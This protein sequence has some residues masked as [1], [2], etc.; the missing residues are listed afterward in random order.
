MQSKRERR[1]T[2]PKVRIWTFSSAVSLSEDFSDTC[3]F[4]FNGLHAH[5]LTSRITKKADNHLNQ[6]QTGHCC[7]LAPSGSHLLVL[8]PVRHCPCDLGRTLSLGEQGFALLVQEEVLLAIN[9]NVKDAPPRINPE[10][11]EAACRCFKH[12]GCALSPV[13][14]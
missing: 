12:H 4:Y 10:A 3:M 5:P 1:G 14:P 9:A 11:A 7:W 2:H 13:Q 6:L 8:L